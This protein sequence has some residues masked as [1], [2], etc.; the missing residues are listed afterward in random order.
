MAKIQPVLLSERQS[1]ASTLKNCDSSLVSWR[2]LK[3]L[4]KRR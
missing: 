1:P 4:A 3:V 2:L